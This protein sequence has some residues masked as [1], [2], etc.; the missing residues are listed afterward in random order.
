MN[1]G[2]FIDTSSEIAREAGVTFPRVIK[3]LV[4]DDSSNDVELAK[5][6][7]EKSEKISYIVESIGETEHILDVIVRGGFDAYLID[8]KIGKYDGI[9]I[10][11]AAVRSGTRGPF[12]VLT[13]SMVPDADEM[14]LRVGAM[15]YVDKTEASVPRVLDRKIRAAIRNFRVQEALRRKLAVAEEALNC[16]V[17]K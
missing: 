8:V 15:D 3:V 11:D 16:G 5:R 4:V 14:A 13:G 17:K 10:I 12:V 7:L 2:K 6:A 9:G 1:T